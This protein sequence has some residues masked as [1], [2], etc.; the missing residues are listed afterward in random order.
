MKNSFTGPCTE[1]HDIITQSGVRNVV[2][3][4]SHMEKPSTPMW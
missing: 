3:S 1:R 4:T 2:S